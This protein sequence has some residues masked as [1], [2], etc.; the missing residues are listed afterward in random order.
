M[1]ESQLESNSNA[2][3]IAFTV[4]EKATTA[5]FLNSVNAESLRDVGSGEPRA[6]N[7]LFTVN[8]NATLMTKTQK[9]QKK[10]DTMSV[11]VV[12]PALCFLNL[13]GLV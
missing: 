9:K 10:H 12:G 5:G 2:Y 3:F 13:Q 6:F 8:E 1:Y 11:K 7:Y 4:E